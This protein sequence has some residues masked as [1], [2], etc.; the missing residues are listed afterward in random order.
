MRETMPSAPHTGTHGKAWRCD[1][2][3]ALQRHRVKPGADAV[4]ADW[5]VEVPDAHHL[6]HSCHIALVHLRPAH[7]DD[8]VEVKVP[9]ATHEMW[10][11]ALDP[12][13]KRSAIVLGKAMPV[14]HYYAQ[15]FAAQLVATGDDA[16]IARMIGAIGL[17]LN[18]DLNPVDQ[19]QWIEL[20]GDNMLAESVR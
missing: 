18:G 15:V 10:I 9:G 6:V 3:A 13:A 4:I 7:P 14:D 20:F 8:Q 16:A 1:R 12:R 5:V 17:I 11:M 2:A 19:P